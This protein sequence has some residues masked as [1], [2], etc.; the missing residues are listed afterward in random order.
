MI[1]LLPSLVLAQDNI[2][3]FQRYANEEGLADNAV[4]ALYQDREGFIWIGAQGSLYKFDGHTFKAHPPVADDST[5]LSHGFIYT[6]EEDR[7]GNLWIGTRGGGVNMYDLATDQFT[8]YMYDAA[9][10]NTLRNN[11]VRAIF[12]DEDGKIWIGTNNG[13]LHELDPDTGVFKVYFPPNVNPNGDHAAIFDIHKSKQNEHLLWLGRSDGLHQ[14]N[15]LTKQFKDVSDLINGV[16]PTGQGNTVYSIFEDTE[17]LLWIGTK[18]SGLKVISPSMELV[19]SFEENTNWVSSESTLNNNDTHISHNTVS[20]I[21]QDKSGQLWIGT[22]GGG[23]NRYNPAIGAFEHYKNVEDDRQSLSNNVV[24]DVLVDSNGLVWAGTYTGLNTYS[25]IAEQILYYG[26]QM[27][28]GR[29]LSDIEVLAVIESQD[30]LVWIGT[31]EGGLVRLDRETNDF[32]YF[33]NEGDHNLNRINA[34]QEDTSGR[35]W[36]GSAHD[37]LYAFNPL[38]GRVDSIDLEA[39]S[40]LSTVQDIYESPFQ[41]G[42]I[43][44]A[45][46]HSGLYRYDVQTQTIERFHRDTRNIED[47][48]YSLNNNYV[49]T[50]LQD[51]KGVFWVATRGGGVNIFDQEEGFTSLT[52]NPHID[53]TISSNDVLSILEDKQG[54]MWFGTPAGGLNKYKRITKSFERYRLGT[55]DIVGILDDDEGNLWLSTTNGILRFDPESGEFITLGLTEG[56]QELL[57]RDKAHFKGRNGDLYFGGINGLNILQPEEF[58]ININPS[59]VLLTKFLVNEVEWPA[60][61]GDTLVLDYDQNFLVFEFTVLDYAEPQK[62]RY[63]YYLKGQD[64]NR[65][66][67][68]TNPTVRYPKLSHGDYSFKLEGANHLGVWNKSGFKEISITINPAYWQTTWFKVLVWLMF[69]GIG[70]G[71]NKYRLSKEIAIQKTRMKGMKGMEDLRMRIAGQLHDNVSANLSTIGLKAESIA[72]RSDIDD[73]ERKRLAEITDLARDSANSIRETS[74]VVNTGFDSLDKLVAAME[75]IGYDMIEEVAEFSFTKASEIEGIPISMDFRQNVYFLYREALHNII[76]HAEAEHVDVT[77]ARDGDNLTMVIR[78]DG[79]GFD[80]KNVRES[81]GI[82]LYH[83]RAADI[84]GRV[85]IESRPGQG[86]CIQLRAPIA[87]V[88]IE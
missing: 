12:A 34:I 53:S 31:K 42:V 28:K 69:I 60:S 58:D 68:G 8:R 26:T 39:Q 67:N 15:V 23:L 16:A 88:E 70:Y 81:N 75:D 49:T 38:N 55:G 36:L 64:K 43:W 40:D 65:V 51:N 62:N 48:E 14:F 2:T 4:Q 44:V 46:S 52:H 57:F 50:L 74:W 29:G 71:A 5:K 6:I 21:T 24:T 63:R 84:K 7:E 66:D 25:P 11:F 3:R 45:T 59:P 83:K 18:Q 87:S 27:D 17:G 86:T 76:K 61:A 9:S 54:T 20:S 33:F 30:G 22:Y 56:L 80:L 77:I 10:A 72:N 82:V 37:K 1:I 78:D 19:A 13:V 79:K 35:L 47:R 41:P 32:E 73:K 85:V